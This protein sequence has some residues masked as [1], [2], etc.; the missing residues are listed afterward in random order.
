VN[1]ED[2]IRDQLGSAPAPQSVARAARLPVGAA[3]WARPLLLLQM[4]TAAA[5]VTFFSLGLMAGAPLPPMHLELLPAQNQGLAVTSLGV[6]PAPT[7]APVAATPPGAT[8]AT[9]LSGRG[10]DLHRRPDAAPRLPTR[11]ET[12]FRTPWRGAETWWSGTR[13]PGSQETSEGH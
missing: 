2:W 10:S 8:Q 9:S 5:A 12:S 6:A 4:F 1:F 11:Q 13:R 7:A 3:L